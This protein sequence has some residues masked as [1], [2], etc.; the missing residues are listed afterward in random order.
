MQDGCVRAMEAV[1]SRKTCVVACV[2]CRRAKVKCD[3][4]RPCSR[5]RHRGTEQECEYKDMELVTS[6]KEEEEE[7]DLLEV[8][9]AS[10]RRRMQELGVERPLDFWIRSLSFNK[11]SLELEQLNSMGWPDRVLARHWEFGFK[12]QEMLNI[13]ICLPPYLQQVTRRA[14]HAVQI[15]MADKLA[16]AARDFGSEKL[17]GNETAVELDLELDRAFHKQQSFGLI[18]QHLHPSTARRAHVFTSDTMCKLL[19]MHPEELLARLANRELSLAITEFDYLC[20]IMFSAWSFATRPGSSFE[21]SARLRAFDGAR[22]TDCT[23]TKCVLQQE[24]DCYGRLKAIKGIFVPVRG[25][26]SKEGAGE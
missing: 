16:R 9:V 11:P 2:V 12:G 20:Y 18:K 1:C 21:F 25:G 5:C 17:L 15:I 24:F 6:R 3:G 26:G 19:G 13:F 8:F 14:L 7:E 23:M 22:G 10:H 4:G